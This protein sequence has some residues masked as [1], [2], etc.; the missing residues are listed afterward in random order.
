MKDLL[1][2]HS[3]PPV[4]IRADLEADVGLVIFCL[5]KS[6]R[7]GPSN[8]LIHNNPDPG[9][10]RTG[11]WPHSVKWRLHLAPIRQHLDQFFPIDVRLQ[12]R[13]W[14]LA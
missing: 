4:L 2:P 12:E 14:H 13:L 11:R 3:G 8:E 10:Y 6:F 7:V 9:K 1:P 5:L